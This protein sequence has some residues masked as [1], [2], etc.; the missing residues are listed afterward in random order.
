MYVWRGAMY[1]TW[2]GIA[3]AVNAI[4][5]DMSVAVSDMG[6]G[7]IL[8]AWVSKIGS[9]DIS[10]STVKFLKESNN[11]FY[12]WHWYGN[13][14]IADAIKNVQTI[15]QMEHARFYDGGHKL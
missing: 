14:S 8:P 9:I 12:A 15:G 6:E 4:V 3:Q 7:A 11:L 1:D 10:S 5:P 13:P 2:K